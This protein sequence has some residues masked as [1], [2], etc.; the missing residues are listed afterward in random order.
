MKLNPFAVMRKSPDG[1]GTLFDPSSN[2]ALKLNVTGVRLWEAVA[3]GANEAE[4]TEMLLKK[5][6]GLTPEQAKS[7]V[8]Y[9]IG[10]LEK[11]SLL[12]R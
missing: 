8:N 10:Q 12:Q 2:K 3:N 5:F 1:S 7:D 4:V 11:K 9:F 6:P